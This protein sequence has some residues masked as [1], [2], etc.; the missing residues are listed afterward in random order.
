MLGSLLMREL[1]LGLF[2]LLLVAFTARAVWPDTAFRGGNAG[3]AAEDLAVGGPGAS[4]W[5]CSLSAVGKAIS[6]SVC[7][8]TPVPL[9]VAALP[10]LSTAT[11]AAVCIFLGSAVQPGCMDSYSCSI[12]LKNIYIGAAE[13]TALNRS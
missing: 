13:G 5:S 3:I 8:C 4:F 9:Q 6:T 7:A 11:S 10:L 12:A 2:V 1:P